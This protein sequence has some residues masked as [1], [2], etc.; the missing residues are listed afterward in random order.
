M[1]NKQ[2]DHDQPDREQSESAES[3]QDTAAAGSDDKPKKKAKPARSRSGGLALLLSLIALGAVAW[4][5][6]EQADV[7]EAPGDTVSSQQLAAVEEQVAGLSDAVDQVSAGLEDRQQLADRQQTLEDN[8]DQLNSSLNALEDQ[9][10]DRYVQRLDQ[11]EDDLEQQSQRWSNELAAVEERLG[12]A[13]DSWEVRGDEEQQVERDLVRHVAMLEASALLRIGQERAEIGADLRGA[14]QAF[15]RAEQQLGRVDDV[16]LDRVR[17]LITEELE[18]LEAAPAPDLGRALA[19]LDR[20]ARE[21][22]EWPMVGDRPAPE[23]EEAAEN[24]E[25]EHWRERLMGVARGLV[26]V[27][28][29]DDLGRTQEQFEAA[30]NLLQLR[31]VAAQLA[32][33]RRDEDGFALQ[34]EAAVELLDDWFDRSS[35]SVTQARSDLEELRGL[36]FE[37]EVPELGAALDRLQTMLGGS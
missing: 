20:L 8:L 13:I 30:R 21:S 10:Q 34:L 15:R 4:L 27:Q 12:Q 32:L 35:A 6:Y 23:P 5:I 22:R 37:P 3:Q 14:G 36:D 11:I 29:R 33:T 1:K 28:A 19:R 25:P 17:R 16:R 26:R 18:A 2:G 24:D 31:L 7:D 9:L